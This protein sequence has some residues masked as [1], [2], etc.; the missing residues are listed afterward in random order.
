MSL[1]IKRFTNYEREEIHKN[2]RKAHVYRT[3]TYYLSKEEVNK[4]KEHR[5]QMKI[6]VT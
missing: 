1:N 3:R 6:S 2:G 4:V 5:E